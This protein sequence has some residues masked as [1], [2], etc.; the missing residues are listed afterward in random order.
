M[1]IYQG[2]WETLAKKINRK[3]DFCQVRNEALLKRNRK[4]LKAGK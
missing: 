4:S 2:L 3:H 1:V